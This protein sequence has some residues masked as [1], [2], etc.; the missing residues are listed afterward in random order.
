MS[1][2]P[3]GVRAVVEAEDR[4]VP[5][6]PAANPFAADDA[7]DAADGA[8]AGAPSAAPRAA[9]ELAGTVPLAAMDELDELPEQ[10]ATVAPRMRIRPVIPA[11]PS[12]R[13]RAAMARELRMPLGRH[14]RS[15]RLRREV[16]IRPRMSRLGP[17][18]PG[19]TAEAPGPCVRL[20]MCPT[21]FA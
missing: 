6:V 21:T 20:D 10:P 5:P 19:R 8:A 16:T 3:V 18:D 7:E 14:R 9:A 1:C 15:R 17:D 4:D 2:W 11:A 13:R 12:G